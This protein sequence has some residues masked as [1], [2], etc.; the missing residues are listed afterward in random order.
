MSPTLTL[1]P[2]RPHRDADGT[3]RKLQLRNHQSECIRV[4]ATTP[5]FVDITDEVEETLTRSGIRD[6]RVTVFSP[7]DEC[8]I[9]VQERESGLLLDIREAIQRLDREDPSDRHG[10]V[11]SPSVV[12]PA[13]AGRLRLG[14]WQRVLL[15]ELGEP[16]ARSV[17]VHIVGE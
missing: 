1:R 15:V 17:V 2:A 13:V 3:A 14:M 11:G 10:L 8:S 7:H 5:D 16:N 9:L 12:L 6:G 4:T